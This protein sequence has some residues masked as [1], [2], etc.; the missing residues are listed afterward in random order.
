MHCYAGLLFLA[1]S[2]LS[3][4]FL[5]AQTVQE[6]LINGLQTGQIN[7]DVLKISPDFLY[8]GRCGFGL[9]T[10]LPQV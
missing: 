3:N 9:R 10:I 1:E 8:S 4:V 7:K 6:F 5:Y 2:N